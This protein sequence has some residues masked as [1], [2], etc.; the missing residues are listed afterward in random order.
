MLGAIF[1]SLALIGGCRTVGEFFSR[2][3]GNTTDDPTT[4]V[5]D[6]A[7][8]EGVDLVTALFGAGAGGVALFGGKLLKDRLAASRAKELEAAAEKAAAKVA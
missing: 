4:T 8:D 6:V 1:A 3:T 2:P 7:I 5:A